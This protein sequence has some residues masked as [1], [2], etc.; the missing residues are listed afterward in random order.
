MSEPVSGPLPPW[1]RALAASSSGAVAPPEDLR[2]N[3]TRLKEEAKTLKVEKV[4]VSK[5]LRNA[6]KKR[7]RLKRKARELTD[8]DLVQ[9]LQLREDV[10]AEQEAQ[11]L[12][13]PLL[14][15]ELDT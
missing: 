2:A 3:I 6:E 15:R 9:V 13:R 12:M 5:A 1:R 7:S 4:K 11:G 14:I 10:R 8:E